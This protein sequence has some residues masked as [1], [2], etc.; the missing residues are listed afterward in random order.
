[1]LKLGQSVIH[2]SFGH[3]I[4][5]TFQISSHA[6]EA[7]SSGEVRNPSVGKRLQIVC[8]RS[9][10]SLE[11]NKTTVFEFVDHGMCFEACYYIKIL[12]NGEIHSAIIKEVINLENR[13]KNL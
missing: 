1:M 2:T 9:R 7:E 11:F 3:F 5:F 4:N 8:A 12:R 6:V 10:D 13:A